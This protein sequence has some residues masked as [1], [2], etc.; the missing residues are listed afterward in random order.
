ME[1]LLK[2]RRT[3]KGITPYNIANGMEQVYGIKLTV[4]PAI[5]EIKA[6]DIDT[7]VTGFS[8]RDN[9]TGNVALFLVLYRYCENAAFEHEYRIYGTLTP[10]CPLCGHSFSFRD[11]GRFCKHCGAK[12]EYRV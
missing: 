12:L 10:Y 6:L 11:A 3:K 9:N 4:T 2:T 8:I 5:G 7:I 1:Y